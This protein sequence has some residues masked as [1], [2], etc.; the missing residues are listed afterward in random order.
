MT[1]E[2]VRSNVKKESH[3]AAA[4]HPPAPVVIPPDFI[5]KVMAIIRKIGPLPKNIVRE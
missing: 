4:K 2:A 1:N 5:G 3:P